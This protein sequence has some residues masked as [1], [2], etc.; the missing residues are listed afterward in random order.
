MHAKWKELFWALILVVIVTSLY[1]EVGRETELITAT[2]KGYPAAARPNF[3]PRVMLLGLLVTGLLKLL[4]NFRKPEEQKP[5]EKSLLRHLLLP[6]VLISVVIV[7]LYCYLRQYL[8]FALSTM[9]FTARACGVAWRSPPS[10][11]SKGG[12]SEVFWWLVLGVLVC[13]TDEV[14][15]S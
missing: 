1:I 4:L 5:E 11:T 6:K 8:G 14:R 15:F 3:W 9:A 13:R 10:F 7:G 2:L 12:P